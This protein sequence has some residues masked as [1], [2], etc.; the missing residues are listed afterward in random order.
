MNQTIC[1]LGGSGFVGKHLIARLVKAGCTVR[2]LTRQREQHR[3]LLV[4]PTL[5]LITADIHNLDVLQHYFQGC[6]A[7]INLVGILNEKRDNGRGF[8]R[9]HVELTRHV[10]QACQ[11]TGVKRLLHMSALHADAHNGASYYLRSKGEAEALLRAASDLHVTCFRPSVIFG[12]GDSFFNNFAQLIKLSPGIVP[13]ACAH[14]R[15]A[16][17][18]VGDVVTAFVQ[19]LNNPHTHGQCYDLCGPK[20]Y[21]LKELMQYTARLIGRKRWIIG[22]GKFPSWLMANIFQYMPLFRPLTRDNYRSLQIDSICDK[23]LATLFTFT[24]TSIDEVVPGYL[25]E[26]QSKNQYPQF[27]QHARRTE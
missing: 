20:I 21:T 14:A 10:I 25:A 18:Y 26:A 15:F 9:V 23:P 4:L 24:P 17:V 3:D 5:E 13:L 8:A 19:S 1:I 27:R 11:Q 12:P 16:P 7:V 6:D 22:L 2:V